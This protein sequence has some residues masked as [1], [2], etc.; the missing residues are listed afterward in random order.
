MDA[1]SGG[2]PGPNADQQT[3]D[4][5]QSDDAG[6]TRRLFALRQDGEEVGLY[7]G[8]VPRRAA[9]KAARKRLQPS[10][11][12]EAEAKQ[13]KQKIV[14]RERGTSKLH[15]YTGWVWTEPSDPEAPAWLGTEVTKANVSKEGI[16][17]LD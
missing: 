17:H 5:E 3:V 2:D 12:S 13:S 11:E 6:E 15:I 14:L 1:D 16:R 10:A 4:E 9:L 8:R 7:R